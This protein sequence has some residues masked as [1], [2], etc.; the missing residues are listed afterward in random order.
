MTNKEQKLAFLQQYLSCRDVFPWVSRC[1]DDE[2]R[3]A[4]HALGGMAGS[5][6]T[7]YS[8]CTYYYP[9]LIGGR[10]VDLS[11][12]EKVRDYYEKEAAHV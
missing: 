5:W 2:A 8:E 12:V 4:L 7:D 3:T 11:T 10:L 1:A 9:V 6:R